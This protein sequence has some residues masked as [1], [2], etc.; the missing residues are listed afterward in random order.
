MIAAADAVYQ[1]LIEQFEHD[2]SEDDS[3]SSPH[4]LVSH[5]RRVFQRREFQAALELNIAARTDAAMHDGLVSILQR[6]IE[7]ILGIARGLFPKAAAENP[8]FDATIHMLVMVFQGEVLD[9]LVFNTAHL[10]EGRFQLLVEI[11]ERELAAD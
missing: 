2:Y 4:K 5:I 9:D 10:S 6:N 3:A 11:A 7:L 1:T 8:K